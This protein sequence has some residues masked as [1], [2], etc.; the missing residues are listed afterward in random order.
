M[1]AAEAIVATAAIT[2]NRRRRPFIGDDEGDSVGCR[3]SDD[4]KFFF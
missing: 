4:T 1:I 3:T 2:A